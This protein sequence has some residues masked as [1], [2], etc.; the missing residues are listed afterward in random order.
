MG[1][2][3]VIAD[4]AA[5]P[6]EVDVQHVAA[7]RVALHLLDD[8]EVGAS[9]DLEVDQ[10]VEAGLA[11]EDVTQ[12]APHDGDGL[13]VAAEAV[14]DAGDLALGSQSAA[15]PAAGGAASVGVQGDLS[16]RSSYF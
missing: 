5:H 9:A 10:G 7:H 14:H 4:V 16:H 2:S 3:T 12:V 11:G 8:D 6:E 1:T 15:G 13:G